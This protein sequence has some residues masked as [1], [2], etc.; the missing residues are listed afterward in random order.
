MRIRHTGNV[1][2]GITEP[3]QK[4]HVDGNIRADGGNLYLGGNRLKGNN[5][6]YLDHHSN[7]SSITAMIFYDKTSNRHGYVY[8]SGGGTDFGLLDGDGNWSY[9]ARKDNYTA[10]YIDN[11]EKMR[12]NAEGRVAIGTNGSNPVSK[13]EV[14]GL[15]PYT[16]VCRWS[17]RQLGNPYQSQ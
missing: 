6:A 13:L 14:S 8:G 1:G 17:G 3:L 4:L 5:G 11:Q 9:R 16:Y 2:I 7:D 10:F 15:R 12:I